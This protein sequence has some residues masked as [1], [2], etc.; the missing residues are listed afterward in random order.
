[1]TAHNIEISFKTVRLQ[2]NFYFVRY[3]KLGICQLWT[4]NKGRSSGLLNGLGLGPLSIQYWHLAT[5]YARPR[6]VRCIT[7]SRP[8]PWDTDGT[9]RLLL[10]ETL[11]PFI[12]WVIVC[13]LIG[14]YPRYVITDWCVHRMRA[15][16]WCYATQHATTAHHGTANL[17]V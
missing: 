5:C 8:A 3:V 6:W 10:A 11:F 4:A 12:F 9:A 17:W 16:V 13:L 1:M 15:V 14:P 2:R 7:L